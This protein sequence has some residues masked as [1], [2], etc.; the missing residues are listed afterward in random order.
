MTLVAATCGS[1]AA[2]SAVILLLI[3]LL[4]PLPDICKLE[5]AEDQILEVPLSHGLLGD[6]AVMLKEDP[7]PPL[8]S[9]ISKG[10][11]PSS[12]YDPAN[13]IDQNT[14]KRSLWISS[15]PAADTDP[16]A[17]T[18]LTLP[19]T[20][21]E[22]PTLFGTPDPPGSIHSFAPATREV[23]QSLI[24][25]LVW[26]TPAVTSGPISVPVTQ[27]VG[28]GRIQPLLK[29]G[30]ELP[31]GAMVWS[32][33]MPQSFNQ[34]LDSGLSFLGAAGSSQ[35]AVATPRTM[36]LRRPNADGNHSGCESSDG[37]GFPIMDRS[38]WVFGT[39][40]S[41]EALGGDVPIVRWAQSSSLTA[42]WRDF[43]EDD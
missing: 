37:I 8:H 36:A 21:N 5:I 30:N 31:E 12:I 14:R 15:I 11:M 29:F 40:R 27:F 24:N 19:A 20:T 13:T 41:E 17:F 35:A 3:L 25:E 33:T 9:A 18:S 23:H 43:N 39:D 42:V 16:A 32:S 26:P 2:L 34:D 38:S 4:F 22:I 6:K 28:I 1:L 7:C 10:P